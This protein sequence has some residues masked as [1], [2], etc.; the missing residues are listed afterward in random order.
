MHEREQQR[1]PAPAHRMFLGLPEDLE[2]LPWAL[3]SIG[4]DTEGIRTGHERGTGNDPMSAAFST[5]R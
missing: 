3:S 4:D 2:D 5:L 1:L